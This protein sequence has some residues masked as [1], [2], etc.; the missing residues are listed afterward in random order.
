M[1]PTG[2]SY[3]GIEILP[4]TRRC[5]LTESRASGDAAV[6]PAMWQTS[7]PSAF[8]AGQLTLV[9]RLSRRIPSSRRGTLAN[10]FGV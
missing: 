4:L 10:A 8:E 9:S 1:G 7:R 3:V 6:I 5:V 2:Q